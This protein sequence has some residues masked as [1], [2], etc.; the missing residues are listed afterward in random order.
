MGTFYSCPACDRP[1]GWGS[2]VTAAGVRY[3]GAV[4]RSPLA[5]GVALLTLALAGCGGAGPVADKAATL[6]PSASSAMADEHLR[7]Q[8]GGSEG[9][10][11]I[12]SADGPEV[13]VWDSPGGTVVQTIH[14]D[15]VLTVPETTPLTFL[16][17]EER[18]DWYE[19]YLPVRPNGATG[20]VPASRVEV[21]ATSFRLDAY[22]GDHELVLTQAG[23]TLETYSIGVGRSDMPTPGGV[24]FLRE[25]LQPPDPDDVYGVYAYGL[26]GFSPVLD[27][28]RG[29]DAVIGLHGTNE[30]ESIGT[31]VSHG[32]LR[33]VND[34]IAELVEIYG[35]PLG[36]PVY[37]HE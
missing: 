22:L 13:D 16:I 15:E 34:D 37:I 36:T 35:L 6:A 26:S 18:A 5:L 4:P 2:R 19:I 27:S 33:M 29:G 30:P 11:L 14:A 31:D 12:A 20:W 25:V 10:A 21:T 8:L 32:C 1:A 9:V 17:K 7:V 28:F 3:S 24:Y 23:D